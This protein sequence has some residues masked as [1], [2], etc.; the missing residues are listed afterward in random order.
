MKAYISVKSR[1]YRNI[2]FNSYHFIGMA[3]S[4]LKDSVFPSM[5]YSS[6]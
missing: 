1:F 3:K 5:D 4:M 2:Y 6:K